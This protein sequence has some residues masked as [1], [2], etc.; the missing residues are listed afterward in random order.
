MTIMHRETTKGITVTTV[1]RRGRIDK[2]KTY[3]HRVYVKGTKQ[4]V[5]KY[6]NVFDMTTGESTSKTTKFYSSGTR[7][8]I[9]S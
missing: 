3:A 9:R 2:V 1:K 8:V 4:L 6:T 7:M 5:E